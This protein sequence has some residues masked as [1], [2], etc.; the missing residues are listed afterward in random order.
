MQSMRYIRSRFGLSEDVLGLREKNLALGFDAPLSLRGLHNFPNTAV[1]ASHV[2]AGDVSGDFVLTLYSSG[3][4]NFKGSI[5]E[6]ASFVGDVYHLVVGLDI[7]PNKQAPVFL[8][9][10]EGVLNG[11]VVA[12][13]GGRRQEEWDQ[14]GTEATI[15]RLWSA[16][17]SAKVE[18][19]LR[20]STNGYD[21]VEDVALAL[22]LV[23]LVVFGGKML[24][25]G[26]G[27]RD[28]V[29]IHD[30]PDDESGGEVRPSQ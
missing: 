12:G 3:V 5:R 23:G 2:N 13:L 24:K 7:Y 15:P 6:T 22:G 14:G 10:Q 16:I 26:V 17:P 29:V 9:K 19:R 20:V 21:I 25:D 18:S 8:A 11:S 30:D 27:S 28:T 4:W 1:Y